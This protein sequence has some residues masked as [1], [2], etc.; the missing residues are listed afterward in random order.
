V[1]TGGIGW[2]P[3]P[4]LEGAHVAPE[5]HVSAPA[6]RPEITTVDYGDLSA[7]AKL[8]SSISRPLKKAPWLASG[9][10]ATR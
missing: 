9:S 10:K 6:N 5:P 2:N 4:S 3:F 7:N 8:S 1:L